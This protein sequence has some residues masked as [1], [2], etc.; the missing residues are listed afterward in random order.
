MGR[1][2]ARLFILEVML[3]QT[4]A[5]NGHQEPLACTSSIK[6]TGLPKRRV[7]SA[8]ITQAGSG[9][10]LDEVVRLAKLRQGNYVCVANVHMVAE[11]YWNPDF[12]E[13]LN[14]AAL[15]IPDGKPLAIGMNWLY[16][17]RQERVAGP[18]LMDALF[19]RAMEEG[20]SIYCYGSTEDILQAMRCKLER[21]YPDLRIAGMKS[22]PFRPLSEA[23]LAQDAQEIAQSRANI[24]LVGL[25]CP[26][27]ERW[28]ACNQKRIPAVMLGVGAAF[29]FY[30]GHVKRAPRWMQRCCLEWLYRVYAEPRRLLMRYLTTNSLFLVLMTLQLIRKHL[31]PGGQNALD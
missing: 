13:I 9:V 20:L 17:I 6:T 22:P 24:V 27:Q 15:A 12:Q 23:E 29:P 3:S 18:D 11:A 5:E 4:R 19:P 25:G 26:K 2:A 31:F 30:T 7:I 1:W 28:M 16:G 10:V 21:D 8:D 14:A